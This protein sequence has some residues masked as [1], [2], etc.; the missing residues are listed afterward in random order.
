MF[1]SQIKILIAD[2]SCELISRQL[3]KEMDNVDIICTSD[4][5][6]DIY[7]IIKTNKPD[8]LLID[9]FIS[10]FDGLEIVE[11]I[12]ADAE[13]SSMKIIFISTVGSPRIIN[14]AF[15]LGADYYI[16][17]PCS[18]EIIIKRLEQMIYMKNNDN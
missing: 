2:T 1:D 5:C 7:E 15:S 13:L 4:D 16:L 12:R 14:M 11:Q 18:P 8:I 3:K 6:S 17:K 9:V 10:R